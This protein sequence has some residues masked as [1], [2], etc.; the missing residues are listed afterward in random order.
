M[1]FIYG[2]FVHISAWHLEFFYKVLQEKVKV[3]QGE[4][5]TLIA[6]YYLFINIILYKS[7][8]K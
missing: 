3:Y 5:E 8:G 2:W 6:K 4:N 1:S 7:I